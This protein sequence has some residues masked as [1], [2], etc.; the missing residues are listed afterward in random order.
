M[1]A[2]TQRKERMSVGEFL[3]WAPD[4][5]RKWQLFDGEPRAMAPAN[6]SHGY[7]QNELGAL[8]RNHFRET[9]RP[10]DVI[11][12]PGVVPATMSA[13]NFRIPDLGVTCSPFD[14]RQSALAEPVVI[15]EILSPSNR[16]DTWSNVWAYTSIPSVQEILV[17]RADATGGDLLRRLPDGTWPDRAALVETE[18][19]FE[20]IGFRTDLNALY[21]PLP[22]NR[23]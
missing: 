13:H 12:N 14:G 2:V 15:V 11:A 1:S 7:L 4:D 18:L 5:G 17:L 23:A 8:L 9:G 20:S 16:A 3:A 10:C 21:A 22:I 6:L 19:V